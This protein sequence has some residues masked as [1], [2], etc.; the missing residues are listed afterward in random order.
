MQA[1]LPLVEY[2]CTFIFWLSIYILFEKAM[3]IPQRATTNFVHHRVK[4]A[5]QCRCRCEAK[6]SNN[7]VNWR[8]NKK[9]KSIQLKTTTTRRRI[10]FFCSTHLECCRRST[11]GSAFHTSRQRRSTLW[12]ESKGKALRRL[13]CFH[14]LLHLLYNYSSGPCHKE[15]NILIRFVCFSCLS[16]IEASCEKKE[17]RKKNKTWST[18]LKTDK[19]GSTAQFSLLMF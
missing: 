3:P 19:N 8:K 18:L 6:Y 7:D 15:E 5:E 2:I 1:Y 17:K 4:A 11:W 12:V 9:Q 14:C 13:L 16:L 10:F